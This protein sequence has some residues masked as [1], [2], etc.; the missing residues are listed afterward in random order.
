MLLKRLLWSAAKLLGA[1]VL[2]LLAINPGR[3]LLPIFSLLWVGVVLWLLPSW[4]LPG[5]RG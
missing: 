2:V 4:L 5:K 1:V 3:P